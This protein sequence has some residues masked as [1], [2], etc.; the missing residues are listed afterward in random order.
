[1]G[2]AALMALATRCLLMVPLHSVQGEW[3]PKFPTLPLVGKLGDSKPLPTF[4]SRVTAGDIEVL[5]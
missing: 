1:M 5:A 3:C 4:Q 2:S